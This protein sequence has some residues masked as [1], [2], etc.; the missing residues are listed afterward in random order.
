MEFPSID[1][2]R[3]GLARQ[4]SALAPESQWKYSNLALTLAGE[5]WPRS[6]ACPM[7]AT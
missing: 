4:S 7:R 3:D 1:E 6:R 2:V 5:V